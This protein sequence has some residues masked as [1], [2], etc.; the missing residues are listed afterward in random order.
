MDRK[1]HVCQHVPRLPAY[2]PPRALSLSLKIA[3]WLVIFDVG[4]E[5]AFPV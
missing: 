4:A 2:R 1:R 3:P 5:I